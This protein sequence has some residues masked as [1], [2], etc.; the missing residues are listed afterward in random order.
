MKTSQ[1][2]LGLISIPVS[3][4]LV[5]CQGDHVSDMKHDSS[6]KVEMDS[7]ALDSMSSMMDS[8][9]TAAGSMMGSGMMGSGMMHSSMDTACSRSM[10][11]MHDS[12]AND[13]SMM[14][15]HDSIGGAEASTTDFHATHH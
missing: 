3:L 14:M 11:A 5:G 1:V 7:M 8:M 13:S 15:T 12:M 9:G 6:S 4:I 2:F 10:Q